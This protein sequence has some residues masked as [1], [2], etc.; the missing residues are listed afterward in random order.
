MTSYMFF[1]NAARAAGMLFS[2]M[3]TVLCFVL[4]CVFGWLFVCLSAF[5]DLP[6]ADHAFEC[7][8]L[9]IADHDRPLAVVKVDG[10]VRDIVPRRQGLLRL[11]HATIPHQCCA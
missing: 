4:F 7:N 2:G 10:K 1:F 11:Q 9:L 6:E 3:P 8:I 5:R